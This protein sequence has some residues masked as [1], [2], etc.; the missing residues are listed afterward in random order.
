MNPKLSPY[1]AEFQVVAT[2]LDCNPSA[3]RN[4]LRMGLSEETTDSCTYRHMPEEL[5]VVGIVCHR[6]DILIRQQ[7]ADKVAQ[8]KGGGIGSATSP[9]PL[10][11]RKINTGAHPGLVAGYSGPAHM[12]LSQGRR[13][14]SAEERAKRFTDGRCLSK[15]GFNHRVA[16]CAAR[17]RV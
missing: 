17:E 12:D 14:I 5:P 10:A 8:N 3:M 2:N 13:R 11:H 9:T 1:Y 6:L 16:E 7:Q 4:T 15:G